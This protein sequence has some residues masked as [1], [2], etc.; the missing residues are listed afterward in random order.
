LPPC[1]TFVL[2]INS[3]I[4]RVLRRLNGQ[5]VFDAHKQLVDEAADKD[6]SALQLGKEAFAEILARS[7]VAMSR[8]I[9]KAERWS[10]V[11]PVILPWYM[12]TRNS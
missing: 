5:P 7:F 11:G 4:Q 6:F 8:Q 10:K 2:D 1:P 3:D 12:K 9:K